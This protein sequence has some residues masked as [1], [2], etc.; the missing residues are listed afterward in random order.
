MIARWMT[1]P[2]TRK[3]WK[4]FNDRKRS[5]WAAYVFFF[6][7]FLA[8]SAEFWANSRP[9]IMKYQGQIYLP[10]WRFYHPTE[11]QQT[12]TMVTNYR[13]LQMGEN[14]WAVWPPIPWDPYESNAKLEQYPGAPSA[15]N[16]LG[17]DDRGR[18]VLTRLLYG[19]RYSI[20]YALLVW[21]FTFF[22]GTILGGIM[23]YAG[24][25]IDLVGQRIVEIFEVIPTLPLLLLLV[26]VFGSSLGMLVSFSVI[27]G[28]MMI[29]IY[30]RA[31]FLRLRNRE[32]VESARALGVRWP[33]VLFKHIFPN[34]LGPIVTFSPFAI[35]GGIASLAVLDYLGF[36]LPP[37]TPSWGELLN[38]GQKFF[39]IAWW[40]AVYPSLALFLSVASLNLIGEG[41]RDAFDPRK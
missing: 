40:L 11:F 39:Q 6:A 25:W 38:Q 9:I 8:V 17:T 30:M 1:N 27:M 23:G 2:E 26:T 16:L 28:W 13:A 7:V 35:S 32:F 24:G 33:R 37:P 3:R 10:V 5:R 41:V 34:A 36:G 22:V 18:D 19:F 21:F 20:A 14:D 29:S 15:D 4:R 12:E 31:E